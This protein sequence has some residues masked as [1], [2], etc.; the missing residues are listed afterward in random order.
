MS[1]INS[2]S[3]IERN[4]MTEVHERYFRGEKECTPTEVAEQI[5]SD[6]LRQK[7]AYENAMEWAKAMD[8]LPLEAIA[9]F[10]AEKPEIVGSLIKGIRD[11]IASAREKVSSV[12]GTAIDN[13]TGSEIDET[14]ALQKAK[15]AVESLAN[16]KD[17]TVESHDK[18]T[19]KSTQIKIEAL[20]TTFQFLAMTLM[21][22][23]DG[24]TKGEKWKNRA[25]FAAIYGTDFL[26]SL[27]KGILGL[28]LDYAH[29]ANKRSAT[30]LKKQL[31]KAEAQLQSFGIAASTITEENTSEVINQIEDNIIAKQQE[32]EE[33]K[34]KRADQKTKAF[35]W[36]ND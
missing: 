33:K 26:V 29:K 15:K 4:D 12:I 35:T 25:K 31:E 24:L 30:V 7:A 11:I 20:W 16:L 23:N 32:K 6:Y 17:E 34:Q 9:G 13:T 36:M 1:S 18:T 8:D 21:T 14:S 19:K 5:V 10:I 28:T 22:R 3:L 2:L 27:P